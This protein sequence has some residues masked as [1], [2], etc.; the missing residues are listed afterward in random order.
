VRKR[1]YAKG[2]RYLFAALI[3]LWRRLPSGF[4]ACTG[5]P[6]IIR[7]VPHYSEIHR[8]ANFAGNL[9]VL[10][11]AY[12]DSC[13]ASRADLSAQ[14]DAI[15]D[16]LTMPN[17]VTKA[18]HFNRLSH[19]ISAVL[20]KVQ[21]P[22]SEIRV[23]DLPSSAGTASLDNLSL[24]QTRYRV[25]SYVLGDMYHRVLYDHCRR[26]I[27]DEQ[28]N[29]LQVAFKRLFFS[30]YRVGVSSDRYTFLQALL[31]FPHSVIAWCMRKLYRFKPG[32]SYRRLLVIHPDVE[33]VLDQGVCRLEEMDVFQPIPGRYEVILSFHLLQPG[34]FSPSTIEA[35]IKNLAASLSDGGLLIVGNAESYVAMQKQGDSLI[36]SLQG[37]SF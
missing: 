10:K 16:Q 25:T 33:R 15:I 12:A 29:L 7:L 34:Y 17:G 23:L 5:L 11:V 1:R 6:A 30:L 32:K 37:R 8:I 3:S 9:E 27:F 20:S 21:L 4:R 22:H 14:F 26:C 35:G 24:L 31:S 18:T 28:G 36:A 13:T 2:K 19:C